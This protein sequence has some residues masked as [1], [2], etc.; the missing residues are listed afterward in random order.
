M[1]AAIERARRAS[2]S[3]ACA[4]GIRSLEVRTPAV[5]YPTA[6]APSI[7]APAIPPVTI[8]DPVI[9]PPIIVDKEG[10]PKCPRTKI[11]TTRTNANSPQYHIAYSSFVQ[12]GGLC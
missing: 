10:E 12:R 1:N 2:G 9:L 5:P 11:L 7:T 4:A 3:E 6:V 8:A